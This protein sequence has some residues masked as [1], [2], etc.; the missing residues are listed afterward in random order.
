M[1]CGGLGKPFYSGKP[2]GFSRDPRPL[3]PSRSS[4]HHVTRPQK[5][6][7]PGFQW[8]GHRGLVIQAFNGG[9]QV[10]W[11]VEGW[12][13]PFYSAKPVGFSLIL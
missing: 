11:S 9:N 3:A 4:W 2:L 10:L 8:P 5:T 13:R 6:S 7:F 1:V 12:G